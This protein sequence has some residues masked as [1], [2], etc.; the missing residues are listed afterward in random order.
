MRLSRLLLFLFYSAVWLGP[1]V[2]FTMNIRACDT[3]IM[4]GH[5]ARAASCLQPHYNANPQG[6]SYEKLLDAYLL[7]SDSSAA[8]KLVKRQ[9]KRFGDGRPQYTVDYWVLSEKLGKKGPLWTDIEIQV[10]KNPYSSRAVARVLE[11]YGMLQEAVKIYE[12]AERQQPK[13]RV[14]FDKAQLY[15]QLGEIDNQYS[16]YIQALEENKGY[17]GVYK[18]PYDSK[19]WER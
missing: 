15:A 6:P 10:V 4:Q 16:A 8:L 17:L 9:S 11:R 3:L 2:K 14:A 12:L 18:A 5:Y 19:H 7:S 13:L 1:E